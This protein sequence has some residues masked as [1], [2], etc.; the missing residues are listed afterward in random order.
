M[1]TWPKWAKELVKAITT[2]ILAAIGTIFATS[3]TTAHNVSQ[4]STS[5]S[6]IKGDTT[7]TEVKI[8]YE[9]IGKAGR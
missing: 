8:T 5:T 6:Y 3:C 9:Q 7:V 1:K 4:S 2:A